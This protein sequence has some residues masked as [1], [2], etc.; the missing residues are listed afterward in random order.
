ALGSRAAANEFRAVAVASRAASLARGV[1][2]P[3]DGRHRLP[4]R[5]RPGRVSALLVGRRAALLGDPGLADREG[6]CRLTFPSRSL[7]EGA[8]PGPLPR[9]LDD[10]REAPFARRAAPLAIPGDAALQGGG[11]ASEGM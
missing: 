3:S 10:G 9:G 8:H 2:S 5:N 1:A 6:S 7:R 4:V 11:A